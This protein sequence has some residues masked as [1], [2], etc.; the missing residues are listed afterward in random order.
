MAQGVGPEFK[1]QYCMVHTPV[2]PALRRLRQ[3]VSS[4]LS[5]VS[6]L[7]VDD[8]TQGL[9]HGRQALMDFFWFFFLAF[10]QL[11]ETIDICLA[12]FGKLSAIISSNTVS[13]SRFSLHIMVQ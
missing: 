5:F 3:E 2:I 13:L 10:S 7:S 12:K 6:L 9:A 8:Q 4:L 1:P 11:L